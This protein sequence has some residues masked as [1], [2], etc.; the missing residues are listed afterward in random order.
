MLH[1]EGAA[2]TKA[3]KAAIRSG[4]AGAQGHRLNVYQD[5]CVAELQVRIYTSTS[6]H[7][8]LYLYLYLSP[9][10]ST[11]I[12]LSLYLILFSVSAFSTNAPTPYHRCSPSAPLCTL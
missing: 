7:L 3:A 11:S 12:Y 1:T 5:P 4:I 6:L 2:G 9:P 8:Y 10:L